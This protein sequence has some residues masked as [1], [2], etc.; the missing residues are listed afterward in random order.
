MGLD[1]RWRFLPISLGFSWPL[2]PFRNLVGVFFY[3]L[4]G[5]SISATK[6][7]TGLEETGKNGKE[8]TLGI[9]RRILK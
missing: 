8:L 7:F 1:S 6:L 3:S 5:D 2:A 9:N 4:V